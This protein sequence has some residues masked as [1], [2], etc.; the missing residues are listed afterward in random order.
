MRSIGRDLG[1]AARTL[2]KSP[3]FALTALATIRELNPR[4]VMHTVEP[5]RALVD[6]ARGPTRFALVCIGVF[7][8]VAVVLA[9]VGLYGVLAT[10]VRQ[11]T[12]EIGVRMAFGASGPSIFRL[13]VGQGMKLAALGIAIG[14]FAAFAVTR[15]MRS[16]LVGV[17]ATDPLT[18]LAITA[19]FIAVAALACW[20]PA[21]RASRLDPLVAL[22]QE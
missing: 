16:M 12:A 15:V 21:R 18:F 13:V 2:I 17:S 6:T 20:V 4:Y 11:R 5:L 19:L 3:I 8:G 9:L 22:R 7:A 10:V 14:L 1:F